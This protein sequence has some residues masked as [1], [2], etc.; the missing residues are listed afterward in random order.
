MFADDTT[1]FIR[2]DQGDVVEHSN[3]AVQQ[4][5]AWCQTNELFLNKDKT[6]LMKFTT[7]SKLIDKCPLVRLE[8]R[9]LEVSSQSKFLGIVIDDVLDW[10]S[11]I[12]QVCS[13]VASGTHLLK[14]LPYFT[15]LT[16]MKMVYFAYI[17]ID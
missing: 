11:H 13:Q 15:N 3:R 10:G 12:K 9:S 16:T 5:E 1:H 4:L 8:G 14:H 7:K 6:V 2:T 17:E